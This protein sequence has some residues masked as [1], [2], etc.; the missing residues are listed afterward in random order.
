M[1]T[2]GKAGAARALRSATATDGWSPQTNKWFGFEIVA[3]EMGLRHDRPTSEEKFEASAGTK[4]AQADIAYAV[5]KARTSPALRNADALTSFRYG[6]L[7]G[8]RK[9]VVQFA[10]SQVGKPYVWGGEWPRP[11]PAG[12]PY[13]AQVAGGFDCSGFVWYT[14][15]KKESSWS[16]LNRGYRGWALPERS[17]AEMAKATP[18]AARLPYGRLRPGDVVLFAP[19]GSDSRPADVYHAGLYTGKGWMIHSSG[20]RAGVSVASIA[21]GTWWHSQIIFGRRVIR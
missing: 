8:A 6:N 7:D 9:K 3:R 2:L 16:P 12:Y 10:V 5:W 19:R 14:L 17:S 21:P 4:M 11:T 13:G 15:R 1:R 18:A 20:S